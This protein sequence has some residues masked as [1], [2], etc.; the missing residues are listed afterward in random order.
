VYGAPADHPTL[1][2]FPEGAYLKFVVIS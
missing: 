2:M 1:P